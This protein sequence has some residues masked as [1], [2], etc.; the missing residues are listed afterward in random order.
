M[1]QEEKLILSPLVYGYSFGTSKWGAFPVDNLSNVEWNGNLLNSL[2]MEQSLRS[3]MY[4]LIKTHSAGTSNFDDFVKGKGKGIIGLLHGPPGSGKT[5]TAEAIAET[6]HMPLY[7]VSTGALGHEPDNIHSEL[8]QILR[9]ATHWGAVLL[10]DEA[11]VFLA[12]RTMTNLKQN[13]IVSVF[14]RELEY[15]EGILLLTTNQIDRIDE[16]FLS[17]THFCHK[18]LNLDAEA[19]RAIWLNF[20]QD[21]RERKNM[22]VKI[23]SESIERLAN[24]PLNGRQIK[25]AM[26]IAIKL[27][28]VTV[29]D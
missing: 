9:L 19:R 6:G 14:L 16:A 13:A 22:T 5:L 2:V 28:A 26:S 23:D 11:D 12:K 27:T 20:I 21:A 24:M 8:M 29:T 4:G 15:Y 1:T 10:L 25:N 3:I 17:R 7:A 18:Y